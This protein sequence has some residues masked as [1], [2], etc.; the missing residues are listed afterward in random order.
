VRSYRCGH[1]L[2]CGTFGNL[3]K[4]FWQLTLAFTHLL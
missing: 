1:L 4:C 2:R 3:L